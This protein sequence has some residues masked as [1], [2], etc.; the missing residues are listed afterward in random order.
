MAAQG[1]EAEGRNTEGGSVHESP[2][3]HQ[4]DAP[5]LLSRLSAA[6]AARDD[7]KDDALRL[8]FEKMEWVDRAHAAEA[9]FDPS[10]G[11]D[12]DSVRRELAD[13]ERDLRKAM[14]AWEPPTTR[15]VMRELERVVLVLQSLYSE[16]EL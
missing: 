3:G 15:D 11:P 13:I 10:R 1:I 2:V 7:Y 8:H 4:S 5:S 12:L 16:D 14:N 9:R 6:E